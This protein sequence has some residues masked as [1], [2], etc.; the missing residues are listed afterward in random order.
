M[1]SCSSRKNTSRRTRRHHL[2]WTLLITA[3][4]AV[5]GS[6]QTPTAQPLPSSKELT[7]S[8]RER[9]RR[10]AARK[11]H[12]RER[13]QARALERIRNALRN[14]QYAVGLRPLQRLIDEGDDRFLLEPGSTTPVGL[15]RAAER[16][17][18]ALD[19]DG[20][21]A[22]EQLFGTVA[23]QRLRDA[24]R[25]IDVAA[26]R[27]ILKRYY[28]TQ[29][30][31]DAADRLARLAFDRG[32]YEAAAAGWSRLLRDPAHA[33]RVVPRVRFA[34]AVASFA[35][36]DVQRARRLVR[37]LGNSRF[38]IGGSMT[39]AAQWLRNQRA[40]AEV[41]KRQRDWRMPLGNL[42]R[43]RTASVSVPFPRARWSFDY[44][45][46]EK[47]LF[48]KP[49]RDWETRRSSEVA[50]KSV[51]NSPL[52]VNGRVI[53][54]DF[55]GIH[56][57][58]LKTGRRI[59]SFRPITSLAKSVTRSNAAQGNAAESGNPF[60]VRN[61]SGGYDLQSAYAGN[62]TIGSMSSDGK[63]L[64]AVDD[65][66]LNPQRGR[67]SRQSPF[68]RMESAGDPAQRTNRL[69][70]L[71]I[72]GPRDDSGV[73]RKP[74]W[75]VGTVPT[76][77]T[78]AI[79]LSSHFFLGPPL[80]VG[81]RLY[82][83]TESKQRLYLV[84]LN[85]ADG[86]PRWRQTL[87]LAGH[88][89]E[90]DFARA[91]KSCMPA[92]AEG[93]VVCPTNTGLLVGVDA[94]TGSL[95]WATLCG[96]ESP[97]LSPFSDTAGPASPARQSGFW[98]TPRIAG[99]RVL[100]LP[101][102]GSR[103]H[104]VQLHSGNTEWTTP[105]GDAEY[106]AA[107]TE[108]ETVIVGRR[109]TRALLLRDGSE[110][111][112]VALGMPSG[113]ALQ[114]QKQ[115]LIPL[116]TGRIAAL[117]IETGKAVGQTAPA[118]RLTSA[119]RRTSSRPAAGL[120]WR[121]GNLIAADGI[122]L[123]AEPRQLRAF[124]PATAVLTRAENELRRHPDSVA[125][126]ID[127]AEVQLLLGK[128]RQADGLLVGALRAAPGDQQRSRAQAMLRELLYARLA[129]E[130]DQR[131]RL[132]DR[133]QKLADT[134]GEKSRYLVRRAEFELAQGNFD[135]VLKATQAFERLELKQLFPMQG[136]ES[137]LVSAAS[138][139]PS[140]IGRIRRRFG[141]A[142]LKTIAA[143]IDIAGQAALA[144]EGTDQLA[145]FLEVYRDWPQAAGIRAELARRLIARG[146]Y[147]HA[148][149]LLMTNRENEH[150]RVR[151]AATAQLAKLWIQR[152]LHDRAAALLEEL[153][154]RYA[155]TT[156]GDGKTTGRRFLQQFP[157]PISTRRALQRRRGPARPFSG[158]IVSAHRDFGVN[159]AL[160]QTLGEYRGRFLTP[161]DSPFELLDRGETIER[162]LSV[163][164]KATAVELGSITIPQRHSY[165]MLS[166]EAHVGHF[167]S[168]GGA[169]EVLGVSLLEHDLGKPLW[170]VVPQGFA[171][172]SDL[173]HV[174]PA[175]RTF[176]SFQARGSLIVVDPATGR[177]L[178]Q[179]NG[180]DPRAGAVSDPYSGLFGD[181]RVLVLFGADR[182]SF[183]VFDTHTG[184]VLRRGQLDISFD[185]VRRMFG[186]KLV[187]V[188][189]QGDVTRL[190]AWD[191]L[192]AKPLFDE[193]LDGPL[194]STTTDEGELVVLL[195]NHRLL[196]YGVA[197]NRKVLEARFSPQETAMLTYLRAFRQ[198]DRLLVNLQ[199]AGR[200][201]PNQNS[202]Y[203][204]DAFI[205]A[206]HV[207]G[208]LYAFDLKSGARLWS[209]R[210]PQRSIL[211]PGYPN[212][213]FLILVGRIRNPEIP[214]RY[215]M[216]IDAVD[217]ETGDTLGH[218][219]GIPADRFLHV[220]VSPD[221]ARVRLYGESST[222]RID[223]YRE[224]PA[225]AAGGR[226][227]AGL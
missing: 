2:T 20:R 94:E 181:E 129:R 179:R 126:R 111:W 131:G 218:A 71:R 47:N 120:S 105:R 18:A 25:T 46:T 11:L 225:A 168:L 144:S 92:Y 162:N 133:V 124:L 73:V 12:F 109:R 64:F 149:F 155:A 113:A 167:F 224:P 172:R 136:D 182:K 8:Q 7:A 17:I 193:K 128:F 199:A 212:L 97:E 192:A 88:P 210:L 222:V 80:P 81:G 22:Y 197:Q 91:V 190:R 183:T 157:L 112:A 85:A 95:R 178:W 67:T 174:G 1:G 207:R 79:D 201:Q 96:E 28:Y 43:N 150:A 69:I 78:D 23:R 215:S 209:R 77:G 134:P 39:T 227:P 216:R 206:E 49:F 21:N 32:D 84:C 82:A 152:G 117:E 51:V 184:A 19:R 65:F 93:I 139:V 204:S 50:T 205:A 31:F 223:G 171:G 156:L 125:K 116:A 115:V 208:G 34:L 26:Y 45:G 56:A 145:R 58:E 98:N 14:K 200:R 48:D 160:A 213:P 186:R 143:R 53:V 24:D 3:V 138:W 132:L 165:P 169:G 15:R 36:G 40:G 226:L 4:L 164:D 121:P 173:I 90:G 38:Q 10:A 175:G 161:H 59:W 100:Y 104:C 148:E 191:P 122:I 5:R 177:L 52:V 146:R 63:L 76:P 158:A 196:V 176:C 214:G 219:E 107:V 141:P 57:L 163:I 198:G 166:R 188:K 54:R 118:V 42:S 9:V 37:Q 16:M 83:V 68:G 185:H 123:S 140:V 66:K 29:A 6:A 102:D 55:H 35:S 106:V 159:V 203:A 62:S 142:S 86:R 114:L 30:G 187:Y 44:A 137:H 89:I 154:G 217:V 87:A 70:A 147:Q 221:N 153:G 170:R 60:S 41:A 195:P 72:D 211:K 202:F 151:A 74:E 110:R 13:S 135:G 101:P 75:T 130:P 99:N 119:A 189:R 33:K 127:V 220:T 194:H 27:D 103:I 108:Q 61:E 180:I